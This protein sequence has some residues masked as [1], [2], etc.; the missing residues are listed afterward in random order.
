MNICKKCGKQ[1]ISL[2]P[3]EKCYCNETY[4]TN[5]TEIVYQ[6]AISKAE[7]KLRELKNDTD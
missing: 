1:I 6:E 7:K 3:E 2:I 4:A 5:H